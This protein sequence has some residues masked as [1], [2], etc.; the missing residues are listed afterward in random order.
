MSGTPYEMGL[1]HANSQGL[2]IL[3]V[4]RKIAEV[5]GPRLD[6]LPELEDVLA[7][8]DRYF[9]PS[10]LEEL[11]GAAEGMGLPVRHMI[12][13]NVGLYPGIHPRLHAVRSEGSAE[14]GDR[15]GSRR[16]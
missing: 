15:P 10:E 9:S 5:I 8:R 1:A 3:R 6:D 2:A 16:Q 7:K 13:L 12:A 14:P 11:E 4:M